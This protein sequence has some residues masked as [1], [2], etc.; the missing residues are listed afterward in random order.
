MSWICEVQA[1]VE[2]NA[3]PVNEYRACCISFPVVLATG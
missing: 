1:L 3:E 2:V